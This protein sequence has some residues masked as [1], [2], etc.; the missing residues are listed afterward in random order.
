MAQ[1]L[2]DADA[3][4]SRFFDPWYKDVD[5]RRKGFEHTR[6]DMVD[7]YRPG[8][9]VATL[10]LLKSETVAEVYRHMQVMLD[11]ARQ[12]WPQYLR[13]SG[14]LD[15]SWIQ[16]FDEYHTAERVA[17]LIDR[18]DPKDFANDLVVMV[19]EFG[20]ALGH[21][22]HQLQP[23]LRWIPEWP[24]WESSLYDPITGNVIPPFHW[25][26]KKFSADGVADGF[27]S[28]VRMC[29]ELLDRPANSDTD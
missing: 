28:K 9:D 6:P 27:V 20:A 1:F 13:V 15:E 12:D 18:S 5:R 3:V 19:C 4:F 8:L 11:A 23:R 16:K 17:A 10:S 14:D 26:M 29:V 22:L 24:Y 25:A 21:V 7:L 2:P